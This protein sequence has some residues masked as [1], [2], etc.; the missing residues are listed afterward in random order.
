MKKNPILL[1]MLIISILLMTA[2]STPQPNKENGQGTKPPSGGPVTQEPQDEESAVKNAA[3]ETIKI[4]KE[5]DLKALAQRVH[6]EKGLRFTPYAFVDGDQDLVFTAQEI[7]Q[8]GSGK[9]YIWGSYDGSGEPIELT[10]EEYF[11]KF[12]YDADFAQAKEIGYNETLGKGNSL[13]NSKEFYEDSYIVEYYFPEIDP[14]YQGLDWR[15]LRLVFEKSGDNWYLTG[16]I[17]DQWTI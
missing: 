10:F 8:A 1:W 13:D 7:Q 4:L 15:S 3:A 9:K 12:V 5:Y 2:C 16:I 6:P 17:H 11:K 14:Q